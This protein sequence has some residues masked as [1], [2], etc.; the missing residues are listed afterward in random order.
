MRWGHGTHQEE[1]RNAYT[2]FVEILEGERL[3]E[4]PKHR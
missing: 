3:L 1:M 4:R 2:F